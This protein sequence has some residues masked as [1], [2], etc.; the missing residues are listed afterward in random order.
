MD[1]GGPRT[2]GSLLAPRGGLTVGE[3]LLR[4]EDLVM[5]YQ[6]RAAGHLG[7]GRQVVRAVEGV[8]LAVRPGEVFGLVGESGC[9]KSTLGRLLL[10]LEP[11]TAG[12]VFFEGQD[13][14]T[15]NRMRLKRFR[16]EAQIIYQDPYSALNPRQRVGR[17]IAE[18]LEIHGIGTAAERRERVA[19]LL[20]VVGLRPGQALRYPHEFS[21]GQ[22]Q[23]IVIARA[24]ALNPRLILAD[25]PVSAL[26]VSIQ[27]QVINLL[28]E[29]KAQFGLTYIF[30]SHDLSVVEHISDRVA[31][32][33]LG[34]I[35][36]LAERKVFYQHPLHPYAKALLS[37][38]PV[39]DPDALRKRQ[40]L[41]GDVPSPINPPP[42]CTFHP[43]C[44]LQIPVCAEERPAFRQ[45]EPGRWA[46]CHLC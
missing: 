34:R 12:R 20:Q 1:R 39:P 43:R 18:P 19:E 25:E 33:Y 44:P 11:P 17:I 5:H 40:I 7:R 27:A 26:D 45:V 31:V 8:S 23:R 22:R 30:I 21:G 42:G 2:P 13:V 41:G 16:R 28:E 29:L 24:L 4:A 37:A 6:I 38:A 36:E 46:A 15:F 3:A 32:M 35:V 14:G 10:H 9:G